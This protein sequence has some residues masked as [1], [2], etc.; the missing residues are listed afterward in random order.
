MCLDKHGNHKM[1]GVGRTY[2][3]ATEVLISKNSVGFSTVLHKRKI[4]QFV[5]L[6]NIVLIWL[7]KSCSN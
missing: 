2:A 5:R 6:V 3:K 7:S 1:H 4:H